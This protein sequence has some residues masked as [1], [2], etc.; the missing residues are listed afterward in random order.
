MGRNWRIVSSAVA[1][2]EGTAKEKV[3]AKGGKQ[4]LGAH[5]FGFGERFGLGGGDAAGSL[6]DGDAA[7]GELAE[8]FRG[9]GNGDGEEAFQAAG[10]C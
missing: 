2:G 6:G 3:S 1:V 5:L 10:R 8:F 7:D 4:G 9:G